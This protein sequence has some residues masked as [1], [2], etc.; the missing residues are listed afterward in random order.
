MQAGH[1]SAASAAPGRPVQAAERPVWLLILVLGSLT[2]FGP[3]ATD[4]YIPAFPE[5]S[6][7]LSASDSAVQLSMTT[8]LAGIVLGQLFV[9]PISDGVGRRR[10]ILG[11]TTAFTVLSV[12]CA[13]TPSIEA[14]V[15]A[16]FLQ[17]VAAST[18]MVLARAVVTDRFHGPRL[19]QYFALL[20][21]VLGVAPIVAPL[22]G[23]LVLTF[24]G[25]RATFVVLAAV[26][27]ALTAATTL[28]VPE[29]LPAQR[30]HPGGVPSAFRAMGRL[31]ADRTFLGYVLAAGFAAGALFTY[32]SGS[33]FVFE[34]VFDTSTATYSLVFAT[35]AAAMLAANSL[36]GR[37]SV[38]VRLNTLL[39]AGIGIALAGTA[40][41]VL[42][43][44]TVGATMAGTWVSLAIALAG[45]GMSFPTSM[46]IS[47]TLG[48]ET[49]GTAAALQGAAT[50]TFGAVCAPLVGVFGGESATPM[51]VI[52]LAAL[53]CSAVALVGLARPWH[54]RG[55]PRAS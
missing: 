37:L 50:F 15:V 44:A 19:P 54:G 51:A 38:R 21:M 17:G 25:W 20:A 34:R 28:V 24:S 7:G 32:I 47:M 9:G 55:E 10:L 4:M 46:T 1:R 18:A 11:G 8:F 39:S 52:M 53:G 27:L 30:R 3:L 2:A 33:S 14:L 16:R 41:Q 26:G 23:S 43:L 12:L 13:V 49:A 5:I 45:I 31:L 42:L 36:S 35:N 48:R 22:L 40:L 29:S 6:A